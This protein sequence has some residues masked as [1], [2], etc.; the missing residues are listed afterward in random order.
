MTLMLWMSCNFWS[1]QGSKSILTAILLTYSQTKYPISRTGE[2]KHYTADEAMRNTVPFLRETPNKQK[3]E[4][5]RKASHS[6][7]DV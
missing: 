5:Q 7:L 2:N 4:Q 3:L 1:I 6:A